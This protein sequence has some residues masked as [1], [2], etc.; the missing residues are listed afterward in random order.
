M[1]TLLRW[2][3]SSGGLNERALL[4]YLGGQGS[5]VDDF[6]QGSAG[7]INGAVC[8]TRQKRTDILISRRSQIKGVT[9]GG[10]ASGGPAA[11]TPRRR[12]AATHSTCGGAID[13][14]R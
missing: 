5:H 9:D 12:D 7:T 10:C 3:A 4:F 8:G 1:N 13:D 2:T 11:V 14:F 6:V